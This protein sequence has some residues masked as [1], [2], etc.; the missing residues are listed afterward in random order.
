MKTEYWF[1]LAAAGTVL[2]L[3]G[4]RKKTGCNCGH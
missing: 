2:Y 1:A 4:I 3:M